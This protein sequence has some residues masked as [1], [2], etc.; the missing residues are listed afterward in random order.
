MRRI[1][2]RKRRKL[3]SLIKVHPRLLELGNIEG[4]LTILAVRIKDSIEEDLSARERKTVECVKNNPS[5]FFSYAKEFS[6]LRSNIGFLKDGNGTVHQ[7][8]KE[9]FSSVFSNPKNTEL[10]NTTNSLP[11]IS[12]TFYFNEED[13][14]EAINEIVPSSST[15][16][17]DIPAKVI[18]AYKKSLSN[19]FTLL[20]KDSYN[21]SSISQCFKNHFIVPIYKNKTVS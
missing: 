2:N 11:G 7:L 17:N 14:I 4:E 13:I 8:L 10:K 21:N 18:K 5:Y 1:L 3:K 16:D 15:S 12:S 6:K 9:Q 19:A 20:W